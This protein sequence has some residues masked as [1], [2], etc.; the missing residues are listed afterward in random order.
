MF[1]CQWKIKSSVPDHLLKRNTEYSCYF[2]PKAKGSAYPVSESSWL[3]FCQVFGTSKQYLLVLLCLPLSACRWTMQLRLSCLFFLSPWY[4][5]WT[6][7]SHPH[8]FTKTRWDVILRHRE[9]K[10]LSRAARTSYFIVHP[11]IWTIRRRTRRT[12]VSY[13]NGHPTSFSFFSNSLN[14][15]LSMHSVHFLPSLILKA[16][17]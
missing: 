2:A 1:Q 14:Y 10:K 4:E 5:A 13:S 3:S 16:P 9:S 11:F 15:S 6:V 8:Y 12:L 17:E 7:A